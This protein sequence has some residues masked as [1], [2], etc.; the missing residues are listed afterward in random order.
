MFLVEDDNIKLI[1]D[2]NCRIFKNG[3]E[4]YELSA[5]D[6]FNFLLK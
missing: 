6:D 5:K 3:I 4:A 2:R 1:G